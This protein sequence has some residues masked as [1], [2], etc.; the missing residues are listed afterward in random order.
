[1]PSLYKKLVAL[2]NSTNIEW[3]D[4]IR[5]MWPRK[6]NCVLCSL[7]FQSC[8][9][10][11]VSGAHVS[12]VCYHATWHPNIFT[13]NRI[14]NFNES[15]WIGN[16]VSSNRIVDRQIESRKPFKSIFKSNRCSICQS[17]MQSNS[18]CGQFSAFSNRKDP[19]KRGLSHSS[20]NIFYKL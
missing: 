12:I 15:N 7:L 8:F 6:I 14:A 4:C 3:K 2:S 19:I 20:V 11:S 16:R 13:L 17:L 1:M 9:N 10:W 18:W 5:L